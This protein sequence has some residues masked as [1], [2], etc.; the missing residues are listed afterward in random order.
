MKRKQK[1]A[2]DVHLVIEH[3]QLP[4]VLLQLRQLGQKATA[5]VDVDEAG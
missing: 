5:E 2:L 4:V 3:F 1:A